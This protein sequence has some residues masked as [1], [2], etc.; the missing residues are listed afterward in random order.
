MEKRQPFVCLYYVVFSERNKTKNR[1]YGM[2]SNNSRTDYPCRHNAQCSHRRK[3]HYSA[4]K[5]NQKP[6]NE[7]NNL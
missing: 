4:S 7:R 3:R 2:T 5:R 1:I 6:S